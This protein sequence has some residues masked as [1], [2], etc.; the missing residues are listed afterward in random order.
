[1]IILIIYYK[2]QLFVF[3]TNIYFHNVVDDELWPEEA[4]DMTCTRDKRGVYGSHLNCQHQ[5]EAWNSCVGISITDQSNHSDSCFL[6]ETDKLQIS[7]NG[8][9]FHR[10]PGKIIQINSFNEG[11]TYFTALM[12]S[13]EGHIN[14]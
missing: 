5:C 9:G 2:Y 1:M 4:K 7:A 11:F 14:S 3:F 10:R 13:I 12:Y 8:F 6:C